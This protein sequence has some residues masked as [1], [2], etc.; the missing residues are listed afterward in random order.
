MMRRRPVLRSFR[1]PIALFLALA[2]FLPAVPPD[3]ACGDSQTVERRLRVKVDNAAV[4]SGA[5]AASPVVAVLERGATVTSYEAEGAWYRIVPDLGQNVVSQVGYIAAA[6]VEVLK[7]KV[8]VSGDFWSGSDAAARTGLEITLAGG[9]GMFGGGDLDAGTRGFYDELR[10]RM[11]G[12]GYAI[13]RDY[14]HPM[15]G[16]MELEAAVLWRFHPRWAAGLIGGYGLSQRFNEFEFQEGSHTLGAS[17]TPILRTFALRPVL[18]LAVLSGGPLT[19]H[20]SAGPALLFGSFRFNQNV[21]YA[22]VADQGTTHDESY[23]IKARR[24]FWGAFAALDLDIR[25]NARS[26][27]VL[28]AT[29]RFARP[30]G[31]EG[32]EKTYEWITNVDEYKGPEIEGRLYSMT[33]N[34]LPVLVVSPQSPGAGAGEAVLDFTGLSLLA[35]LRIRF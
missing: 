12:L 20:V 22:F 25:L 5:D 23:S 17:S 24:T 35:G 33:R 30:A 28:Q 13:S 8:R 6:D 26:A 16:G 7:E 3:W 18:R 1:S 29:Y 21:S 2:A 19:L 11:I 4:R 27:I 9:Y 14:R 32:T 31:W 10:A 15:S 34:S